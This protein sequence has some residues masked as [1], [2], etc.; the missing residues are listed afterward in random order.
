MFWLVKVIMF[1]NRKLLAFTVIGL[2]IAIIIFVLSQ[3]IIHQ[4]EALLRATP[5]IDVFPN[6]EILRT[7]TDRTNEDYSLLPALL[8]A[9][10]HSRVLTE[11]ITD[12]N[13]KDVILFYQQKG[14]CNVGNEDASTGCYGDTQPFGRY[15]I[16]IDPVSST[17]RTR[18]FIQL[19]WSLCG[20]EF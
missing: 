2:T 14:T 4:C 20:T 1:K 16:G 8:G 11:Y 19:D 12:A 6:S 5:N 9:T 17:P 13:Y 7:T 3:Q 18:F 10:N 15:S